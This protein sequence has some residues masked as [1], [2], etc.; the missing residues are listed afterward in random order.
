MDEYDDYNLK[1]GTPDSE[2]VTENVYEDNAENAYSANEEVQGSGVGPEPTNHGTQSYSYGGQYY[3]GMREKMPYEPES[4]ASNHPGKIKKSHSGLKTVVALLVIVA[5]LAGL[6]A[7]GVYYKN[8]YL[9]KN[10]STETAS[11]SGGSTAKKSSSGDA[12]LTISDDNS[13][14]S[15][16]VTVA[17][18]KTSDDY[19][20]KDIATN[21]L[22]CIVAITNKGVSEVQTL[23][24]TYTQDSTSAGSGVI[25]A[26]T[27]DELLIL[28]NYHVVHGYETLTVVFSYDEDSEN[29]EAVTAQLKGYDADL[30]L[31]VIAIDADDLTDEIKENISIAVI[32]DSDA[33]NLGEQVVAIGNALGYGQSVT[34][35]IVSALDR[36]VTI[37]NAEGNT[38]SNNYIQTDAAINPGNS[39]GGL[40]NMKG[41][42]VGINSAKVA[43]STVEGM[44]YAFPISAVYDEIT[45]MMNAET[46]VALSEDEQGYICITGQTINSDTAQMYNVPE[47]VYVNSVYEGLAADKAGLKEGDII[48][49]INDTT[50]A[51]MDALKKELSYHAAGETVTVYYVR[52]SNS[53][54]TYEEKS[55]SLTL[56]SYEDFEKL[57]T[58][59]DKNNN[60]SN[61]GGSSNQDDFWDYYFGQ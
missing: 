8:N 9:D 44:G 21:C 25:V 10:N 1:D 29:P 16:T 57:S 56:S 43:I 61:N 51:N 45:N 32:G 4:E 58:Q 38:T 49:K 2:S 48:Y 26:L 11:V 41:E 52:Y 13:S 39:G 30:D 36:P 46:K 24:G 12:K 60:S 40:F 6:T 18:S 47:G 31:A 17:P 50:I 35:G 59:S 7:G 34:T 5:M 42:L 3:F 54:R 53:S 33:L 15:G 22:P 14:S 23:W 27:D 20:V 19:T 28:T 55:V 37:E